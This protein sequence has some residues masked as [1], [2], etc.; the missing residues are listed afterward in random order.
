M[1]ACIKMKTQV[2]SGFIST[3]ALLT[4]ALPVHLYYRSH[5]HLVYI[6]VY[7]V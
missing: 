7:N 1:Y 3:K 4:H 2:K 5:H 6:C